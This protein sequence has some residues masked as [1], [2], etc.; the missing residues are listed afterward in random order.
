[1]SYDISVCLMNLY[2]KFEDEKIDFQLP[3][4]LEFDETEKLICNRFKDIDFQ[5]KND[6]TAEIIFSRSFLNNPEENN[7]TNLHW[8]WIGEVLK[9]KYKYVAMERLNK[10]YNSVEAEIQGE[11]SLVYFT[12]VA[13]GKRE[14]IDISYF[15]FIIWKKELDFRIDYNRKLRQ[16]F[17]I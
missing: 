13:F 4:T 7:K 14:E 8:Y 12:A 3:E 16:Y 15:K 5:L 10:D 11:S 9:K 6:D 1:M 17:D 2:N